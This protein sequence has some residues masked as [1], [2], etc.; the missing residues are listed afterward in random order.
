MKKLN[1][2]ASKILDTLTTGLAMGDARKIDNAAGAF[3]AVH[4]DRIGERLYSVAHYFRQNG[5]MM[6]DPDV[7]FLHGDDGGW[8]PIEITMHATGYYQRAATLDATGRNVATV[9]PRAQRDL[10]TFC[11]T[12]MRNIKAQQGDLTPPPAADVD[13]DAAVLAATDT[14]AQGAAPV[15]GPCAPVQLALF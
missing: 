3:M 5:D 10:A 2:T 11:G 1:K 13:E 15:S 9:R 12:W 8:Y 4:V 14:P 6:A 7:V